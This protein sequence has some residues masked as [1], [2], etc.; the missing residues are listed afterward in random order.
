MI[1]KGKKYLTLTERRMHYDIVK[2]ESHM[3]HLLNNPTKYN[4][5]KANLLM[6]ESKALKEK[7]WLIVRQRKIIEFSRGNK[8]SKAKAKVMMQELL[9]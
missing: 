8:K 4:V 7:L 9:A 2:L 6:K 1:L 5:A 3:F